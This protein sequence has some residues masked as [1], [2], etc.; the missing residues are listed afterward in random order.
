MPIID[1]AALTAHVRQIVREEMVRP[2]FVTQQ[3]VEA[4]LG[5][6]RRDYLTAARAKHF[7]STKEGRRVVARTED[8][9]RYLE[10]RIILRD[11]KPANLEQGSHLAAAGWRRVAP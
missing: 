5:L 9:C 6:P 11:A 3:N 4:V 1:E 2:I 8:V 10:Q 7:A